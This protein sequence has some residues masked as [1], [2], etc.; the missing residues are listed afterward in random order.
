M[1]LRIGLGEGF[2]VAGEAADIGIEI[3]GSVGGQDG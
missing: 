1:S 2:A 3:E